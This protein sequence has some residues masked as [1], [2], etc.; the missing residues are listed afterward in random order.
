MYK[1]RKYM[2]NT[3]PD[4]TYMYVRS[5]ADFSRKANTKTIHRVVKKGPV[6]EDWDKIQ[7][8]FKNKVLSV[9]PSATFDYDDSGNLVVKSG[10]SATHQL[11]K[12]KVK[13]SEFMTCRV[14]SSQF[15]FTREDGSTSY[16]DKKGL[17]VS[18]NALVM[19]SHIYHNEYMI[20][21]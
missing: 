6:L 1:G 15:C 5:L 12:P 16:L 13:R 3:S 20:V 21:E 2:S 9:Y 17:K 8:D 18:D 11:F 19:E 10:S 14:M 4:T 7:E